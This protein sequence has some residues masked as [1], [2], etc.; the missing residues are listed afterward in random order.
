MNRRIRNPRDLF[1]GG[2]FLG[3]GAVGLLVGRHYYMGTSSSM[4]PGYF[5]VVLSFGLLF[6]GLVIGMRGLATDGQV[7]ELA[8]LR[9]LVAVL[10]SVALFGLTL[11][12]FGLVVAVPLVTLVMAFA[13]PRRRWLEVVASAVVMSLFCVLVFVVGLDQQLKIWGF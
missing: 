6:F 12:R 4:G 11:D 10:A 8:S 13:T 1:A 3:F 2:L 9:P 7:V 5:P